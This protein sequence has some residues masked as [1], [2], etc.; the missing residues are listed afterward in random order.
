MKKL[1]F[2]P[3]ALL[4]LYSTA[5]EKVMQHDIG[6]FYTKSASELIFS[7]A[8]CGDTNSQA[9]SRPGAVISADPVVRFSAFFNSTEQLHYDFSNSFGLYTGLGIR[10]VGFISKMFDGT[11]NIKVKYRQYALG[12]PLALKIGS[13]RN[14]FFFAF[15]GE[16]ELF[17]N[18]KKKVFAN[19]TKTKYSE[20]FSNRSELFNPS[21]FAEVNFKGGAYVRFR[22]YIN[23][24]LKLNTEGVVYGNSQ[25]PF[26][27][28]GTPSKLM[29]ISI[30]TAIDWD[31][32]KKEK[33]N[34]MK[35]SLY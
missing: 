9:V 32:V 5:Q 17:F 34:P 23:D 25:T 12:V 33:N 16:M 28:D 26:P 11:T 19:D 15:G 8:D 27:Y 4:S 7:W 24:F 3:L 2:L 35:A 22:Y 14:N 20:W 30:G 10:N 21:L 1:L 13:M 31:D 18:Y 6:S 29:Y